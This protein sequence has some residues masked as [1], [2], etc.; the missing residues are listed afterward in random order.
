MKCGA[1][2]VFICDD[3]PSRLDSLIDEDRGW[4]DSIHLRK[5]DLAMFL[6]N[7][8]EVDNGLC[9]IRIPGEDGEWV[10]RKECLV[11]LEDF[12]DI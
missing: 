1:L 4:P 9:V 5:G 10:T 11:T 12:N 6:K 8:R 2:C 7:L 3:W